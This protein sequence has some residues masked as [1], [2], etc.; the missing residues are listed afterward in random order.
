MMKWN[1]IPHAWQRTFEV[2]WES[3]LEGSRPIGVV[4]VNDVGEII[5][6]GKS[7]DRSHER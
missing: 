6:T 3:F 2:A 4:V 1:E 5:S 7:C